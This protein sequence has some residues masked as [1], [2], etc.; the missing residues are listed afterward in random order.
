MIR[1]GLLFSNLET[2][3]L[4]LQ[5]NEFQAPAIPTKCL[6]STTMAKVSWAQ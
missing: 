1:V 3:F 5:A 4:A 2:T 6:H